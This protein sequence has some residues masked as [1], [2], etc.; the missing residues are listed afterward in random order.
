MVEVIVEGGVW[1][2]PGPSLSGREGLEGIGRMSGE[3]ISPGRMTGC[4]ARRELED[5]FDGKVFS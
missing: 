3:I 4:M 1:R 2:R 5:I